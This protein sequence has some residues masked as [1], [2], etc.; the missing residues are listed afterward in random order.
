LTTAAVLAAAGRRI[1]ASG[2]ATPRF[3]LDRV[4][5]V[6][7][8]IGELLARERVCAVVSSAACGADLLT[9]VEAE[10]LH[11]GRRI[12]LPFPREA[13]RARS[14]VDR[15]GEWGDAFDRLAAGAEVEGNLI[16]LDA[17][18]A[19]AFAAANSMIL[20]EAAGLAGSL[21]RGGPLRRL[22]LIVWDGAPRPGSDATEDFRQQAVSLGFELRTILTRADPEAG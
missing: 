9:L 22:A 14:V 19:R 17:D 3:P 6:R 7:R 12:V 2:A 18:P 1:D 21:S 16:I 4:P 5:A 13:F 10:R 11:V 8:E 20:E 15:P